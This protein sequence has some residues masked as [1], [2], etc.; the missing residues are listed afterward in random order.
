MVLSVANL[1]SKDELE[2]IL[3]GSYLCLIRGT[4]LVFAWKD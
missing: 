1:V 3:D 2:R 4:I